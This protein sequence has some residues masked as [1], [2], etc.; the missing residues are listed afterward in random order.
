LVA[1][2]YYEF[3]PYSLDPIKRVLLREGVRVPLPA[4][5]F[6][7]L[8]TL[9][10][11]TGQPVNRD[12]LMQA[13][14]PGTEVTENTFNVTLSA[15]RKVL[16][17]AAKD[18]QYIVT[19]PDGYCFVADVRTVVIGNASEPV[20]DNNTSEPDL[21]LKALEPNAQPQSTKRQLGK[22]FIIIG[23]TL[24]L[25]ITILLFSFG[26]IQPSSEVPNPQPNAKISI[27]GHPH[28]WAGIKPL[29][30]DPVGDGPFNPYGQY[31]QGQDFMSIS[32]TNDSANL[33][34]LLEFVGD[35]TGGIEIFLDTDLDASTGCDGA[36]YLI[37][38]WPTAPGANLALA[39]GRNCTFQDDFPGAVISEAKGRFAEASVPIDKLRIIT[40]N[41]FGVRILAKSI[42]PGKGVP[43]VVGPPAT[44]L[45][46]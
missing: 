17:E 39:D 37:F 13:V 33:Y 11:N 3:G 46:K 25:G 15:V 1:T 5:P 35:Y 16:G 19:R 8:L 7:L 28:D 34:F 30:T 12:T 22:F 20:R 2:L 10:L 43:D 23:A 31:Y 14:W 26:R 36:E 32:L 9:I 6:E 24:F 42:A 45:F 27:D 44:Y 29:L 41:T 21:E 18:P 4:K 40:P 38:V